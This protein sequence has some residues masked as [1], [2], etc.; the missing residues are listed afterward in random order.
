VRVARATDLPAGGFVVHADPGHAPDVARALGAA[1]AAS[2][3][4]ETLDVLRVEDGRAWYG[5]DVGEENLLHETGLLAEYHSATKGCYVGQEV[6]ARLEGRGGHVN[7]VLRGLRLAR[8]AARGDAVLAD[9]REAGRVTTAAVSPREGA[10]AMAYVHRAHAE[11]G[12]VVTVGGHD[13]TVVALPFA[14]RPAAA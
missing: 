4:V 11:P 12:T 3:S 13:A 6:V 8:P 5:V 2:V 10:I 14:G 9:G 7:K 1:G